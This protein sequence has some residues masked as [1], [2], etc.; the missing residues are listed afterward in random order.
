M[1]IFRIVKNE[2]KRLSAVQ[3]EAK[4]VMRINHQSQEH[5]DAYGVFC[6][7]HGVRWLN[8]DDRAANITALLNYYHLIRGSGH[9]HN[10]HAFS[11]YYDKKVVE[12]IH[13]MLQAGARCDEPASPASG[14]PKAA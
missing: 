13:Q 11:D 10:T 14:E 6:E 5:R 1:N 3:K 2:I 4:G 7:E 8:I 9:R 12:N